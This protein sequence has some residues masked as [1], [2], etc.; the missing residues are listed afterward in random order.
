MLQPEPDDITDR[1]ADPLRAI[2]ASSR[3]P[4]EI[5]RRPALRWP[6]DASALTGIPEVTLNKLRAEGEHPKLYALGRAL[7]T[8]TDDLRDWILANE[9]DPG[10]RARPAAHR[11]GNPASQRRRARGA[12]AA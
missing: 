4:S 3:L 9:V 1:D 8:T 12:E 7:F 2:V 11:N 5:T 10:Y 6:R